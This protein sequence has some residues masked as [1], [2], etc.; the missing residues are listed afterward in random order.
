MPSLGLLSFFVL[1]WIPGSLV[2]PFV[3]PI[4]CWK[5]YENVIE[6]PNTPLK[7]RWFLQNCTWPPQGQA[8]RK[9][10]YLPWSWT[11][12]KNEKKMHLSH[13]S[14]RESTFIIFLLCLMHGG[15]LGISKPDLDKIFRRPKRFKYFRLDKIFKMPRKFGWFS[16]IVGRIGA[17]PQFATKKRCF[18]S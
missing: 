15:T 17:P 4:W 3:P 8:M 6:A 16:Q 9:E 10:R 7:A 12:A 2:P 18:I 5:L 14:I 1:V 13:E 11:S